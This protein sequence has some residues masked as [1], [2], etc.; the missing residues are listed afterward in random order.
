M[1]DARKRDFVTISSPLSGYILVKAPK[2][3][4]LGLL[5]FLSFSCKLRLNYS[6][7]T[8]IIKHAQPF[9]Y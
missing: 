4:S 7:N 8:E 1:C 2:S 6:L 9:V 5:P 3:A